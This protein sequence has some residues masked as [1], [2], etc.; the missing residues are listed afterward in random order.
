MPP[1]VVVGSV[2]IDTIE[3]PTEKAEDVIGGAATHFALAASLH[4]EVGL[5]GVAGED[6]PSNHRA[7]LEKRGVCLE[8]LEV[9]P[10]GKTFRWHGRYHEDTNHRDTV[11]LQLNVY[12]D[13]VPKV[14][15]AYRSPRILFLANIGTDVQAAVADAIDDAQL[16]AMDT[17]ELWIEMQRQELL[18]LLKRVDILFINEDEAVHLSD[19]HSLVEAGRAILEMGPTRVVL[20]KGSHGALLFHGDDVFCAPAYPYT[21]PVD[22]TGAGDSFAG[23]F[24][25]YLAAN[26]WDDP[27]AFRRAVIHGSVMGAAN[28]EAFAS[29]GVEAMTP[30]EVQ[31]R[32]DVFKEITRF[33]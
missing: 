19:K 10:G 21:K 2:G 20:K 13:Y 24:L 3:T 9:V 14:P 7:V 8:G 17:M 28:V 6:Y 11:E 26:G 31:R 15:D 29:R 18:A 23:G 33:E 4:T 30:E 1:I 25:G 12:E 16:V 32:Y 5:I 22:P 27:D